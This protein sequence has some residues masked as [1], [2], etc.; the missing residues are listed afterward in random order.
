MKPSSPRL[1]AL[2][3]LPLL[4]RLALLPTSLA[5]L[6]GACSGQDVG[7]PAGAGSA[8][9]APAAGTASAASAASAPPVG[10]T[11]VRAQ[12][13][14]IPVLVSATGAV[15][16]MSS[17][18][19]RPQ[20]TTVIT[21][22]HIR[23]GQFVRAGELLFTLDARA[24]EAN[25]AR[26]RAQ[27]A[28]DEAGLA[29]AQRQLTRSRELLAQ[30]FVSQGA[31]DTNIALMESQRALVAADRAAVDAARVALS[32]ARITAPSAGRV[33]AIAVYPGSSVQA[34]QTTLV[35]ITQ[36]DPINV[37]FSLPQRHLADALAA[38]QAGGA[39]VS[40]TLPEGAGTLAG[41]LQF[42]DSAVDAASGT[43]KVKAQFDNK[44][45]KLWPGAFVNVAMTVRTL[46]DAI[47]IPQAAIIE[48]QRGP[49]VYAVQDGTAV[50]RPLKVAYAQGEEVA[51]TGLN[52]GDRI[53][54]DGRQN[55]RPGSSVVERAREGGGKGGGASG[56][57]SGAA[58][59]AASGA[60]SGASGA[61]RGASGAAA[62]TQ[63]LAP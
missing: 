51:V 41:R 29:D 3:C 36:L 49:I 39:A 19:I 27:M 44:A 11:T 7:A 9:S 5:L 46:K 31:V 47:V 63:G 8:A 60:R 6:L 55:L 22:V 24:D 13:K 15:T 28:K 42:V 23:E 61:R 38:L 40:A 17:V 16:P 45:A 54:L 21:R 2:S 48:S 52:A 59:S 58:G 53:V 12:R 20:V 34:N 4:R 1:N 50:A 32:N 35:T 57:A 25:V 37:S 56:A 14:D 18:D 30:N 10:I 43:V 26:V 62:E 33:G